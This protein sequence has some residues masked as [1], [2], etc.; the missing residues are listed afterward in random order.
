[1]YVRLSVIVEG[2]FRL[3]ALCGRSEGTSQTGLQNWRTWG[4]NLKRPAAQ[5]SRTD[6]PHRIKDNV[7]HGQPTPADNA[8]T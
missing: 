1:M 6:Q 4:D 7:N 5:A 3:T 8:T 2:Q